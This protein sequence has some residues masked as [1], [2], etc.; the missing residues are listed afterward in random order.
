[1]YFIIVNTSI[2][3]YTTITITSNSRRAL[4]LMERANR[5]K[6]VQ[7]LALVAVLTNV[8]TQMTYRISLQLK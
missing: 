8:K 4:R 6:K 5:E 3:K 1:M 7:R 2:N